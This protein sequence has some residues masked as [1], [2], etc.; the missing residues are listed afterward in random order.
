M[1]LHCLLQSFCLLD[2]LDM[3][4]PTCLLYLSMHTG[5]MSICHSILRFGL[6]PLAFV[7]KLRQAK[8]PFSPS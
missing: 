3:N 2:L 5:C 4:M 6:E 8:M 7:L 1:P